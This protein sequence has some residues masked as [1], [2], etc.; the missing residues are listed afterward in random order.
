[1]LM[2]FNS[3][4][5]A[6]NARISEFNE[7][8]AD[9]HQLTPVDSGNKNSYFDDFGL[10]WEEQNWP[11][12]GA[13]GVYVFCCATHD[14][15]PKQAVYVGKSSLQVMGHRIYAHLNPLRKKG[16]YQWMYSGHSYALKSLIAIPIPASSP[17]CLA[18]ALEEYIITKGLDGIEMMN[19]T[20]RR[21]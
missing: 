8:L 5:D 20:G 10:P 9:G 7:I 16:A 3:V 18:A 15:E 4:I 6:L 17:G 2:K 12:K 1:M 14:P 19:S 11:S 21:S 13:F